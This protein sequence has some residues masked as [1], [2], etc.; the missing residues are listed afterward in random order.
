MKTH[1]HRAVLLLGVQ[2]LELA[3]LLP[4]VQAAHEDNDHDGD[5]DRH[6]LDPIDL[7]QAKKTSDTRG[8]RVRLRGKRNDVPVVGPAREQVRS[9]G[10]SRGQARRQPRR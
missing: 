1:L 5:D 3:L 8:I 4:I 9:P 2:D 10:K 6:T 7:K